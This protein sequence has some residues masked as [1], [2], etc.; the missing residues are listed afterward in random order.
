MVVEK[1]GSVPIDSFL[2]VRKVRK[3]ALPNSNLKAKDTP[4]LNSFL[5][6][7][8]TAVEVC[9]ATGGDSSNE[10]CIIKFKLLLLYCFQ[11]WRR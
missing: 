2:L 5:F 3:E 11:I 7:R 8:A 6:N 9:D 4:S 10:A 1:R